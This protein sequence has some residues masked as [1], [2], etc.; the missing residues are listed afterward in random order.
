MKKY[1][2]GILGFIILLVIFLMGLAIYL[3]REGESIIA[4]RM[5]DQ[6]FHLAGRVAEYRDIYPT[7]WVKTVN[8]Y[9]EQRADVITQVDGI[10]ENLAVAAHEEVAEGQTILHLRNRDIPLRIAK[11][12]GSIEKAEAEENRTR[13][14]Y[15]RYQQL[16]KEN[17][18]SRQRLDEAEAY[19]LEARA[20]I[21]EL[22]AQQE[23]NFL[24]QDY[25]TVRAP[26]AGKVLMLYNPVGTYVKSGTPVC[27]IADF[28][29]LW[30]RVELSDQI[31]R[32][33][34]PTE[35]KYEIAFRSGD[36]T[37][38]YGTEYGA[39]NEGPEQ[40]FKGT[41]REITPSL[42]E[43]AS[44]RSILM[45]IDN[46]SGMLEPQRYRMMQIRSEVPLRVLAVPL[47]AFSDQKREM[48]FVQNSQGL[49][50]MRTV[51]TGVD[52]GEY[53]EILGGLREGDIVITSDATGLK[54]GRQVEVELEGEGQ[55]DGNS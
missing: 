32:S 12:Q 45:E 20:T 24:M 4:R 15:E 16:A 34:T 30:L 35:G 26:I 27:L 51:E 14:T 39:G 1:F 8:L 10:I 19:Y 43:K 7:I 21:R 36:F 42:E 54:A 9:S 29:K 38:A 2:F 46:S 17:A 18:V 53:I 37:K 55:D 13:I 11:T 5:E 22:K 31:V 41:I 33:L 23:S 50:E 52:D 28:S 25:Q 44:M 3:N 40:N 49:L 47:A 48:V 6:K